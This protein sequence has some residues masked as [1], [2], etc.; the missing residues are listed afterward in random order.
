MKKDKKEIKNVTKKGLAVLLAGTMMGTMF[1]GCSKAHLANTTLENAMIMTVDDETLIVEPIGEHTYYD[2]IL[3]Y[4][5]SDKHYKDI[6]TGNLYHVS[7]YTGEEVSASSNEQGCSV[8]EIKR[9]LSCGDNKCISLL[10]DEVQL[11]ALSNKL[12]ADELKKAREG[13]FTDEDF[14]ALE[15]RVADETKTLK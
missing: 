8:E 11:T 1:A 12:T 7:D 10:D 4:E 13:K 2:D 5:C 15:Q 3:L 9:K 14:V 6:I